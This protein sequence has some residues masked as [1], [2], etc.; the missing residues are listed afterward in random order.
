M[1]IETAGYHDIVIPWSEPIVDFHLVFCVFV[2]F[3]DHE[4][5]R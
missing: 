3:C 1:E 5:A 2:T 4:K